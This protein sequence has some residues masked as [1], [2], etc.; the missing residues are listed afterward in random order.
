[1]SFEHE[2][3]IQFALGPTTCLSEL[4]ASSLAA[5]TQAAVKRTY[6]KGQI[7]CLEGEPCPGLIIIESGWLSSVK[8][9]PQGREQEIR[10]VGPGEMINE[11]SVMAGDTNLVTLKSLE[12]SIV[13]LIEQRVFF[14]LMAKH[15]MLSNL[16][17]KNLAKLVVQ[18][19]NLVEDLSLRNVDGRLARLLL[20]RS[21]DGV[22]ERQQWST[23]AEMAAHI[24]TT[25][26]V[27]SRV[28]GN[29][30][31]QGAIRLEH[32]QIHILDKEILESVAFLNQK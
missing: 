31:D 22:I 18:L 1:M 17:T 15:P 32:R 3:D 8:I 7:V 19:L 9:S 12:N 26:V 2:R 25:S 28:L 5:I 14:E 29:L 6:E 11:I 20:D 24:G 13:W 10:L 30:E 4:D 16:I 23:Q 27:I 21:K